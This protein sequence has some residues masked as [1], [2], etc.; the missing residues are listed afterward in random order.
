MT[1]NKVLIDKFNRK[2]DY[3]RISVTDR[4]NFRCIYCMP[5]CGLDFIPHNEI[6]TFDEIIRLCKIFKKL[7]VKKIRIT[8][9]EPLARKGVEDL[10]Y[11]LV[12]TVGIEEV[13]ITT[14][15]YYLDRKIDALYKA[16]VRRFNISL[17]AINKNVLTKITRNSNC[18]QV[19]NGINSALEL[20][21]KDNNIEIK[22]NTVPTNVNITEFV[23]LVQYA[24]DNNI[25]IRFIEV[26][27][28]GFGKQFDSIKENEI[29]EILHKGF[30]NKYGR[31]SLIKN[32][33]AI[34]KCRYYKFDNINTK[35]G[36]ISSLSHKFCDR[37]NRIRLT[38]TGFLKT[39]LQYDYGVNLKQFLNE[40]DAIIEKTII[41]AVY[42]KPLGHHFEKNNEDINTKGLIDEI[43]KM[44]DIGG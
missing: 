1:E 40:D 6:L 11:S 31:L 34:E 5:E 26:M 2:I 18:L 44:S 16:G 14:N 35:I 24:I 30:E 12:H 32:E 42:N 37:C 36:F 39:C 41:D 20:R 23:P 3:L 17:D 27:P 4:C 38:S 21:K 10:I 25:T 9:G 22:I 7:G 8:G 33:D 43:K 28:I 29:L 15:G 19:F 13:P